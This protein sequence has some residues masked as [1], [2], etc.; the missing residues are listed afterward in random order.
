MNSTTGVSQTGAGD[1]FL[2]AGSQPEKMRDHTAERTRIVPGDQSATD[3]AAVGMTPFDYL[4][5]WRL[6]V[7]QTMLRKKQIL[8]NDGDRRWIYK[9]DSSNAGLVPA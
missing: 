6:G 8:D 1:R 7:A 4:T 9:Y 3:P 5:N 2:G